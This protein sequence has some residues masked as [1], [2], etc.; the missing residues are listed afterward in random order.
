VSGHA[1]IVLQRHSKD[2][3]AGD[4]LDARCRQGGRS[5]GASSS[6][7]HGHGFC[8]I[9]AKI[10]VGS[11]ASYVVEFDLDGIGVVSGHQQI[12]VICIFQ[13]LIHL[14]DRVEVG[15]YDDETGRT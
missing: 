12:H 11:P 13:Q 5:L 1:K 2:F 14:V 9:E 6:D 10:I 8:G 7:N 3:H 4:S 15:R